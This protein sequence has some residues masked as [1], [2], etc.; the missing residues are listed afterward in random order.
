MIRAEQVDNPEEPLPSDSASDPLAAF[1]PTPIRTFTDKDVPVFPRVATSL[2]LAALLIFQSVVPCC[3]ISKVMV[4]GERTE[5][6]ATHA[7]HVCSCCP[8]SQSQQEPAPSD[9]DHSPNDKCPY[10]GGL[11]FHSVLDDATPISE[12]DLLLALIGDAS[13]HTSAQVS[14]FPQILQRQ[15]LGQPFLNTGTR[16]LI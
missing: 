10:C 16:L 15:V 9:N 13:K 14:V 1:Q 5:A 11:L 4:V 8:N 12:G 7:M 3:A 2:L 6:V